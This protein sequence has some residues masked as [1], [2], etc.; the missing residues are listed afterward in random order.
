MKAKLCAVII[1]ALL[2]GCTTETAYGPCV[3]VGEDRDPALTYKL[4]AWNVGVGMV[5][6]AL[7]LPPVLVLA[8]ATFCPVG[9]KFYPAVPST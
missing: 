4:S 3:G 2:S 1:G 9:R 6:S 7:L 5:F 8:D